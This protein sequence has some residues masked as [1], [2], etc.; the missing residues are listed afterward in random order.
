M[1]CRKDVSSLLQLGLALL[2]AHITA[3]LKT[4]DHFKHRLRTP[5]MEIQTEIGLNMK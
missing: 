1:D 4:K 3:I 5:H 2:T